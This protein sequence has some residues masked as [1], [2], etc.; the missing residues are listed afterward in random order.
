MPKYL[1]ILSFYFTIVHI[2]CTVKSVIIVT[3]KF[4]A[5]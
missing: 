2:L 1:Y 4:F 3:F 5:F